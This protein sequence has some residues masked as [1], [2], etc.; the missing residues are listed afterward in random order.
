[1]SRHSAVG[2]A[3]RYRLD[4]P[5]ILSRCGRNFPHL[6]TGL[7]ALPPAFS[8]VGIGSFRG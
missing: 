5:A 1:M 6:F 7:V 8:V 3:N 2:I 4:G